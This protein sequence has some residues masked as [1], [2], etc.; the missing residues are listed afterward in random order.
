[1]QHSLTEAYINYMWI[2]C[3]FPPGTLKSKGTTGPAG[4]TGTTAT[5]PTG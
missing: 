1:M 3:E 5:A 4:N 2:M